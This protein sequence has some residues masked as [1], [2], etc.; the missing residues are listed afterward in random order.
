MGFWRSGSFNSFDFE[1]RSSYTLGTKE[2]VFPPSGRVNPSFVIV[3]DWL[4][5]ALILQ[6][7]LH[8]CSS[9]LKEKM[10]MWVKHSQFFER[11]KISII[12]DYP[13]HRFFNQLGIYG[14]WHDLRL[15]IVDPR[16]NSRHIEPQKISHQ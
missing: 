12:Q 16:C 5:E 10:K 14:N 15:L 4:A 13:N 6:Q 9:K 3:A 2:L 1:R 8:Q 11:P 7:L